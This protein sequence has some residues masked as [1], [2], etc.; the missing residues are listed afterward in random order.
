MY[1]TGKGMG[2]NLREAERLL[3]LAADSDHSEAQV[4]LASILFGDKC[5]DVPYLISV[6]VMDL[7]DREEEGTRWLERAAEQGNPEALFVAGCIHWRSDI[8]STVAMRYFLAADERGHPDAGMILSK[9][10]EYGISSAKKGR[11]KLSEREFPRVFFLIVFLIAG[12]TI[13]Q[14]SIWW[15]NTVTSPIDYSKDYPGARR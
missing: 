7:E 5:R 11:Q 2:R 13:L 10:K 4:R 9:L 1:L 14:A 3:R 8:G 6:R 15:F 12:W